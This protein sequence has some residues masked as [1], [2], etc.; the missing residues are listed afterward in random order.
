MFR[1]LTIGFPDEREDAAAPVIK[2]E[3]RVVLS[4]PIHQVSFRNPFLLVCAIRTFG[5]REEFLRVLNVTTK[6]GIILHFPKPDFGVSQN[7]FKGADQ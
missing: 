4:Q 3:Q 1:A 2:R 5:N 7:V 6:C